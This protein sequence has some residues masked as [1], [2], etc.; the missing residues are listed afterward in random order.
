VTRYIE[1]HRARF[2]VEPICRTLAVAPST[3]YA[4]RNRPPSARALA[5]AELLEEIHAA[6][7]GFRAAYGARRTWAE[8]GRRGIE[9]GRDRVARLMRAAGLEGVRRGR[10][11]RTTTPEPA[12]ERAR[13]LVERRFAAPGPNRLWV[14]DLTYL[15]TYAGFLYLAFILDVFARRVVGWQIAAH[16]RTELPLDALEMAVALRRPPAGLIA[17]TDRGSQGGF[18]RSWGQHQKEGFGLGDG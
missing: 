13:D 3:Y 5:D 2:G 8:L 6:R 4:Q 11:V 17:H 12:A 7:A 1:A 9:V 18:K 14:A 10:R 16:M 15:R